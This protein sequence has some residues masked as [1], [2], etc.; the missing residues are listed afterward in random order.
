MFYEHS[1]KGQ[2]LILN[3]MPAI[4]MALIVGVFVNS[5][6]SLRHELNQNGSYISSSLAAKD[7]RDHLAMLNS[8]LITFL[9]RPSSESETT[10]GQQ[11]QNVEISFQRLKEDSGRKYADELGLIEEK[12]NQLISNIELLRK[13]KAEIGFDTASG[14]AGRVNKAGDNL[15]A[16]AIAKI[17][18]SDPVGVGALESLQKARRSQLSYAIAFS[19]EALSSFKES[20]ERMERSIGA[21]FLKANVQTILKDTLSEYSVAF[22]D[23]SSLEGK[24]DTLKI[25]TL[26]GSK[27]LENNIDKIVLETSKS[28]SDGNTVAAASLDGVILLCISLSILLV[29][30]LLIAGFLIGRKITRPISALAL[31]MRQ[32]AN[33]QLAFE[34]HEVRSTLREI[35]DMA[36]S[37]VVFRDSLVERASLEAKTLARADS[38]ASRQRSMHETI[39]KFRSQS[40]EVIAGVTAE[41]NAMEEQA[42]QL[43]SIAQLSLQWAERSTSAAQRAAYSVQTVAA[44]AEELSVSSSEIATEISEVVEQITVA[45]RLL[46]G[47]DVKVQ[48]LS[49]SATRIGDVVNLIRA[50]ADQTNLLALNATIEASRAGDAG[51]GFAVVASEVKQLADES[52][53]ATQE[54]ETQVTGIQGATAMAAASISQIG[55]KM[56]SVVEFSGTVAAAVSQQQGATQEITKSVHN[57]ANETNVVTSSMNELLEKSNEISE[58]ARNVSLTANHLTEGNSKLSLVVEGFI[59]K[60]SG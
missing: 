9:N 17:D 18:P 48:E 5:S 40:E 30:L 26:A 51:K 7:A 25:E 34:D 29:T 28:V 54:I 6:V 10:L 4:C 39:G 33:G 21:S 16:L 27:D 38:D 32:M 24:L 1:V 13:L 43:A 15:E 14:V 37:V 60:V 50:I 11:L 52:S 57:A 12:S 46:E 35:A 45:N 58:I 20:S 31:V 2:I 49:Q 47:V 59:E 53:K 23:W 36:K 42:T 55:A 3:V 44:S 22:A 56:R 41:V 8:D 19:A